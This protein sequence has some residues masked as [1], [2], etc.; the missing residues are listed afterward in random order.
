MNHDAARQKNAG[1]NYGYLKLPKGVNIFKEEPGRM[2]LDV[3]PYEVT[4]AKHPDRDDELEIAVVGDLWYKRPFKVHRNVGANNESVVCPR[5]IGLRC[6]ICELREKMLKEGAA[7]EDTDAMRPSLRNLYVVIP[8]GKDSEEKP[9]I[10]DISQYLFQNLLNQ[11]LEEDEDFGSFPDL[12]EG[13][14]LRIRFEEQSI[15]KNKFSEA[16]RIDFLERDEIY[17]ESIL[18]KCPKL[19][20]CLTIHSYEQLE[21]MFLDLEAADLGSDADDEP[22]DDKPVRRRK[23]THS[24]EKPVRRK[25]PKPEPEDADPDDDPDDD[26]EKEPEEKEPEEKPKLARS[27]KS[28]GGKKADDGDRCPHGHIFGKDCEKFDDCDTCEIWDE[29]I[30]E[31]E[32][33]K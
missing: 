33:T 7:K 20:D 18:E 25:K 32:K 22:E 17:D 29:C 12:E 11:E 8:L 26:D 31:Q 13:L 4:D 24:E 9:M 5:S 1:S 21:A 14:T 23:T 28:K 27:K 10:W 19:D 6:P 30:D 15:G 3:L 16:S 2:K